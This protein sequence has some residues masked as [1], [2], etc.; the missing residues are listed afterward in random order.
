MKPAFR[1]RQICSGIYRRHA[2]SWDHL[3]DLSKSLRQKLCEKYE[4]QYPLAHQ[5]FQSKDGTRR[6]LSGVGPQ[7]WI[8]SVFIRRIAGIHFA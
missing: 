2:L 3:T 6:Y 5:T 7:E 8:E 1:A 4:I